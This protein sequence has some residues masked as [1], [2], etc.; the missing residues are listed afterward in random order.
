[1]IISIP[2]N[3][4]NMD[5]VLFD[6]YS[7]EKNKLN[8]FGDILGIVFKDDIFHPRGDVWPPKTLSESQI[9]ECGYGKF[10]IISKTNNQVT[11]STSKSMDI[12]HYSIIGETM[13][14]CSDT[15]DLNLDNYEL[16]ESEIE[17]QKLLFYRSPFTS[18]VDKVRLL[19]LGSTM[20]LNCKGDVKLD[21]WINLGGSNSRTYSE[22]S[23]LGDFAKLMKARRQKVTLYFTGGID[24]TLILCELLHE[25]VPVECVVL[26]QRHHNSISAVDEIVAAQNISKQLGCSCKVEYIDLWDESVFNEG[27]R[28][29]WKWGYA[30]FLKDNKGDVIINGLGD[31]LYAVNHSDFKIIPITRK[32]K[33]PITY[34]K[35]YFYQVLDRT[36]YYRARMRRYGTED[37]PN[38]QL[39]IQSP[40][41]SSIISGAELFIDYT[42]MP[43]ERKFLNTDL[44]KYRLDSLQPIMNKLRG[45]VRLIEW[46]KYIRMYLY[47]APSQYYFKTRMVL[48]ILDSFHLFKDRSLSLSEIA[49]PRTHQ[50]KRI[51]KLTGKS[52]SMLRGSRFK[53][54][55]QKNKYLE[56]NRLSLLYAN[57]YFYSALFKKHVQ[58]I[59]RTSVYLDKLKE[60]DLKSR[61]SNDLQIYISS[62]AGTHHPRT[63]IN[64]LR[65]EYFLRDLTKFKQAKREKL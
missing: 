12:L 18:I 33:K 17:I 5:G 39:M 20:V 58:S 48:P 42:R 41:I 57:D 56:N 47:V 13:F 65:H 28:T 23:Y 43:H 15:S 25:D 38:N 34:F 37:K 46:L 27:H 6:G 32:L 59:I 19:P 21:T 51:K 63:V 10:V 61:I 26:S 55:I 40:F 45:G 52:Y 7:F 44:I 29:G 22:F 60:S 64:F 2:L 53:N 30:Y 36:H 1:M 35:K 50:K 9:L 3:Q 8:I 24:S 14:I 11:V 4:D 16:I 62:S 31:N 54:R 49:F